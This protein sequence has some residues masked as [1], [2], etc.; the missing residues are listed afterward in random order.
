MGTCYSKSGHDAAESNTRSP[1]IPKD[2]AGGRHQPNGSLYVY[3]PVKDQSGQP[4]S[5][6]QSSAVSG[7]EKGE[8]VKINTI[9]S[10]IES[11]ISS[12]CNKETKELAENSELREATDTFELI[13]N[14]PCACGENCEV[15]G[16]CKFEYLTKLPESNV[17]W[18]TA[19]RS[20]AA[21]LPPQ[22]RRPY[23]TSVI[24]RKPKCK[25]RIERKSSRLSWKS[26]DSLDWTRTMVTSMD[27]ATSQVSDIF[28]DDVSLHA[29]LA[30]FDSIEFSGEDRD[31][32][33]VSISKYGPKSTTAAN[34]SN[35]DISSTNCSSSVLPGNQ[36]CMSVCEK[37][38]EN[39]DRFSVQST[40]NIL[41]AT[42]ESKLQDLVKKQLSNQSLLG[43]R[44]GDSS[45]TAG[46]LLC[47]P[48]NSEVTS[49]VVDGKETE[50]LSYCNRGCVH[51]AIWP[52]GTMDTNYSYERG[53]LSGVPAL[54]NSDDQLLTVSPPSERLSTA[55]F[56]MAPYSPEMSHIKDCPT[57]IPEPAPP[58]TPAGEF[59]P[60]TISSN[61][62]TES[63]T[64]ADSL[65]AASS[66]SQETKTTNT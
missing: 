4:A 51:S 8:E 61:T 58:E 16:H 1:P 23:E 15:N 59:S 50:S 46:S 56:D 3:K 7:Q 38:I 31:G 39:K 35:V 62:V 33:S 9:D 11:L 66:S 43:S 65:H 40:D 20:S 37:N 26:T 55:S 45:S 29:P 53:S 13:D 57:E 49:F 14:G 22:P 54:M 17:D 27:R 60:T 42:R 47:L 12:Q 36:R 5:A 24:H 41:L 63:T 18:T 10:G 52:S 28:V 48:A 34:D 25:G 64:V 2:S 21:K 6:S 44:E 19:S 32:D 30:H